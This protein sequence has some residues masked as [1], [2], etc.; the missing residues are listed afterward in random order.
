MT[1]QYLGAQPGAGFSVTC[2]AESPAEQH[3]DEL[4]SLASLSELLFQ[5]KKE[6]T[7]EGEAVFFKETDTPAQ[8]EFFSFTEAGKRRHGALCIWRRRKEPGAWVYVLN[9]TFAESADRE[10]FRALLGRFPPYSDR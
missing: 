2:F 3:P 8:A 6:C 4:T 10:A 5:L 9:L 7:A 1:F